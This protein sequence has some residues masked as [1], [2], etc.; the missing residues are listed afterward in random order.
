MPIF[1]Q[2]PVRSQI[3]LLTLILAPPHFHWNTKTNDIGGISCTCG[4]DNNWCCYHLNIPTF[5][6]I[7][8]RKSIEWRDFLFRFSPRFISTGCPAVDVTTL[9]AHISLMPGPI[10]KPFDSM[11]VKTGWIFLVYDK[12]SYWLY[13]PILGMEMFLTRFSQKWFLCAHRPHKE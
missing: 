6:H 7:Y 2:L 12:S 5:V 11:K 8:G 10:I 1:L 3:T 4:I 9:I 13:Y